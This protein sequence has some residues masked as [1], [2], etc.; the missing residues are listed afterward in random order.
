MPYKHR[1]LVEPGD[2]VL[3]HVALLVP[4]GAQLPALPGPHARLEDAAG[5]AHAAA[6]PGA[7]GAARLHQGILKE[8]PH[9]GES[10]TVGHG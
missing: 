9:G 10:V 5:V 1:P 8:A 4:H 6:S 7:P 2:A 3:P